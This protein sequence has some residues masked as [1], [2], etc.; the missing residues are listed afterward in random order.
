MLLI[1]ELVS[2][3]EL[4]VFFDFR[5]MNCPPTKR[6]RRLDDH[7]PAALTSHDPFGD[8]EDFTQDD[9]DEIDII[10]SQAF[11]QGAPAGC[12]FKLAPAGPRLAHTSSWPSGEGPS[13]TRPRAGHSSENTPAFSRRPP[14]E[15]TTAAPRRTSAGSRSSRCLIM[16]NTFSMP[17]R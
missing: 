15:S 4:R 17:S 11:P 10:A 5:R 8:D 9:L 7:A 13:G 2:N 3:T 16:I 14:G 12:D 6:Q 1:Q